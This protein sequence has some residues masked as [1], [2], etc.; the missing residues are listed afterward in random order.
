[1]SIDETIKNIRVDLRTSMDGIV[2]QSMREKGLG[3]KMNFGVR[4][5]R[6][7]QMA[8]EY[9][10]SVD[11]AEN[12]WEQETRELKILATL[13][14]PIESFD[15]DTA[16]RWGET[17]PNQEIR[18]QLSKNI[19]QELSFA[20]QLV[21]QWIAAEDE[22]VRTTGYWLLARLIISKSPLV[23]QCNLSQLINNAIVDATGDDYFLRNAAHSALRFIGRVNSELV[24]K[25]MSA[26]EP[27]AA[28]DNDL[29]KELYESL[30]FEFDR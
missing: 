15:M 19:F 13:L 20:D 5:M 28:S 30:S 21:Q 2:S 9:E 26:V 23:E 6:L 22:E 25:I 16:Q 3:Y 29:E 7:Q 27:F 1:M 4:I 10:K 14:Y 24:D 8:G 11:L 12:L 18:E 17:I